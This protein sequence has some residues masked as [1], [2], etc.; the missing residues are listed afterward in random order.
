MVH[1]FKYTRLDNCTWPVFGR[2]PTYQVYC[3]QT[4]EVGHAGP[5]KR[6][7]SDLKDRL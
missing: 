6:S 2:S 5:E 4:I 7:V 1:I 3:S